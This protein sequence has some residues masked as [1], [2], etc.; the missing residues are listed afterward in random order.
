LNLDADDLNCEKGVDMVSCSV[1]KS[2][3]E[4]KRSGYY[5]THYMTSLNGYSTFYG[6]DPIKIELP[7]ENEMTLRIED[8]DNRIPLI[9]GNNGTLKFITN[10]N[11]SELNIFNS[12]DIEELTS[13]KTE[14]YDTLGV[15]HNVTCRLWKPINEKIRVFC[16]LNEGINDG[17]IIMSQ[18]TFEYKDY[19]ISIIWD[20]KSIQVN[21]KNYTDSFIYSDRQEIDVKEGEDVY[22]IK[23]KADSYNGEMIEMY[24]QDLNEII[25][26]NCQEKEKELVCPLTKDMIEKVLR[27]DG[28]NFRFYMLIDDYGAKYLD[29]V[30][31][32]KF[33]YKN[34]TKETINVEITKLK[35]NYGELYKYI[36]Y[37]TNVDSI[38]PV[39]TGRFN[40]KFSNKS[41]LCVFKK[42]ENTNMLLLCKFNKAGN[43][44]LEPTYEEI[45]I[46]NI[47]IK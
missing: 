31:D 15:M 27:E 45:E 25:L 39:I 29:E 5:Y 22:Y 14:I 8:D 4:R 1:S 46:N 37:E 7:Y 13:F 19:N 35:E 43:Y 32:I 9:I 47:N 2:H 38:T 3:F 24:D 40:L 28:D 36:A 33:N 11:D 18:V 41:Q 34:V 26:E 21:Q 16:K 20:A 42:S 10:Y 30:F 12:S 17:E 6:I 23:F 44:Y